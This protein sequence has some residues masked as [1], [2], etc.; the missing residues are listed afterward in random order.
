MP[1]SGLLNVD[2]PPG[3]TSRDVVNRVQRV[4]RPA[5]VG[6]AGTLDPLATGVLV[7]CVGNST[8]LIEYVQRLPK[9]Y[10]GTFLLDRS[11]PTEDIEGEVQVLDETNAS[12]LTHKQIATA[13]DRFVGPIEQRPPAFSAKK[14]AGRR[15]Y[16]L[17]R[18]GRAVELEPRP[19]TVYRLD[20]LRW[21]YPELEVDLECSSGTYVRSLGRDLAESLGTAAVMSALRRT[22]IGEFSDD[23]AINAET[24]NA[25]NLAEHVLPPLRAVASLP[26]VTLPDE[27]VAAIRNG[28][29]LSLPDT[30]PDAVELAAIDTTGQLIAVLIP[31][32]GNRWGAAKNL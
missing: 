25:E 7:I 9:R 3:V 21:D 23:E 29:W 14:V 27:H 11:S 31:R 1:L 30:S 32:P 4:V 26:R 18:E 24:L 15:A 16:K 10:R 12:S 13:A 19:V 20:V 22:A 8:R 2:K 6:H 28:K 5:K 17:A